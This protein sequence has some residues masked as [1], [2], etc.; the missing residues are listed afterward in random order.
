MRVG[1]LAM[2]LR[3][4]QERRALSVNRNLHRMISDG[5]EVLLMQKCTI[6][7]QKCARDSQWD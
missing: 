2:R 3:L 1:R 7:E 5:D 6:W 4:W